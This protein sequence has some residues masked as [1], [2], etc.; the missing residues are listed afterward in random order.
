MNR[1]NLLSSFLL[2]LLC[3]SSALVLRA[4]GPMRGETDMENAQRSV[5]MGL[6]VEEIEQ[7]GFVL[8]VEEGFDEDWEEG[9]WVDADADEMEFARLNEDDADLL[10]YKDAGSIEESLDLDEQGFEDVEAAIGDV[11][12]S[13]IMPDALDEEEIEADDLYVDESEQVEEE[14]EWWQESD[15]DDSW[16]DL[17]DEW[18]LEALENSYEEEDMEAMEAMYE[19]G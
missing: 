6:I 5:E 14:L 18:E 8:D 4:Q 11:E 19:K 15:R 10:D 13:E 9:V 7:A 2:A 17:I 12:E 3:G 16:N 1:N